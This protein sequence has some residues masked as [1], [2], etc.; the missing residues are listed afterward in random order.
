MS[1]REKRKHAHQNWDNLARVGTKEKKSLQFWDTLIKG[2]Q[3]NTPKNKKSLEKWDQLISGTPSKTPTKNKNKKSLEKWDQLI[4]GTPAELTQAKKDWDSLISTIPTKTTEP[5]EKKS[6]ETKRK[7]IS[8]AW[9]IAASLVIL[10][11]VVP[12][13]KFTFQEKQLV[14]EAPAIKMELRKNPQGQKSLPGIARLNALMNHNG[15]G[16]SY[17]TVS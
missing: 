14:E 6:L 16:N 7:G 15:K 2:T 1:S 17:T 12:V 5:K 9:Y 13:L 4:N 3:T 8:L 10:L 11:I